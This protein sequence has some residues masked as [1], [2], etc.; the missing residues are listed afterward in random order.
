MTIYEID[1]VLGLKAIND[2]YYQGVVLK[3]GFEGIYDYNRGM[4]TLR[5]NKW[6]EGNQVILSYYN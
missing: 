4:Y 2:N 6:K 3:G 1:K 5:I